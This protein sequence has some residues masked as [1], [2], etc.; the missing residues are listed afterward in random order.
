MPINLKGITRQN[1]I[2]D[3]CAL[4]KLTTLEPSVLIIC[5]PQLCLLWVVISGMPAHEGK[6]GGG[7]GG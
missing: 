4:P 2:I 6:G 1:K 5:A 3:A 7:L